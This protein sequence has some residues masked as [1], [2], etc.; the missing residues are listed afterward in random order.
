[1]KTLP[2]ETFGQV[3]ALL[4]LVFSS[5]WEIASPPVENTYGLH[6]YSINEF[7][8]NIQTIQCCIDVRETAAQ[9]AV[10][11]RRSKVKIKIVKMS[12][13]EKQ[14]KLLSVLE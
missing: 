9:E 5:I 11:E 2:Q 12:K 8:I 6:V 4:F 1:V 10:K 3:N 14:A 7:K 13:Q